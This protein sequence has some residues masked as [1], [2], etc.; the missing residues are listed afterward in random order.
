MLSHDQR[1]RNS[2]PPLGCGLFLSHPY[3]Y[4]GPGVASGVGRRWR[5]F[6]SQPINQTVPP[7]SHVSEPEGK[8]AVSSPA[9]ISLLFKSS[10]SSQCHTCLG[11]FRGGSSGAQ[12]FLFQY[13]PF[14]R[15]TCFSLPDQI[16]PWHP[17]S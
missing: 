1:G 11:S 15:L 10:S 4:L 16:S 7:E 13:I 14:L 2:D 9:G 8:R 6:P 5:D 3:R 17:A 12:L